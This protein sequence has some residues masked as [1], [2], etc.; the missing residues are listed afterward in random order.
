MG[1]TGTFIALDYLLEQ[2][3]AEDIVDVYGIVCQM[4]LARVNM[5]Q[6]VVCICCVR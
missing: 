4:R 2:A 1:R 3:A 6:T 5:I